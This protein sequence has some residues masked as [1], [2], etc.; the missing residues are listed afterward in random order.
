M[1][2][3]ILAITRRRNSGNKNLKHLSQN[4]GKNVERNTSGRFGSIVFVWMERMPKLN[5]LLCTGFDEVFS[6][7]FYDNRMAIF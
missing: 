6:V 3:T 1:W 2:D 4:I 5:V 7:Y